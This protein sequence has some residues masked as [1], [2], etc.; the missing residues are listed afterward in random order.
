MAK[1]VVKGEIRF[2]Y[3]NKKSR[4]L[5]IKCVSQFYV[6][7]LP[8]STKIAGVALFDGRVTKE[9]FRRYHADRL[10]WEDDQSISFS[11]TQW[12]PTQEELALLDMLGYSKFIPIIS[13]ALFKK[14]AK[15][16]K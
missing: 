15:V 5:E 8:D 13:T 11:L 2:S 10:M 3:S 16:I 7:Y 9:D 12:P 14:D 6:V 4:T 1:V